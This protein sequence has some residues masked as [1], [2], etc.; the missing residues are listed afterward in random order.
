[1]RIDLTALLRDGW[2]L[3]RR[4]RALLLPL[5][6]LLLFLPDY[7]VQLL[8]PRF[9]QLPDQPMDEAATR[10]VAEAL[11]GWLV[12]YGG[13]I[14][15]AQLAGLWGIATLWTIYLDR[16]RPTLSSAFVPGL[17]LLWRYILAMLVISGGVILGMAP[18]VMLLG[19]VVPVSA[20]GAFIIAPL[21]YLLARLML[22]GPALAAER[23]LGPVAA[24]RRSWRLTRGQGWPLAWVVASITLAGYVVASLA[25]VVGDLLSPAGLANPVVVAIV[26]AIA[27]AAQCAVAVAVNL[28]GVAAYRRLSSNG[29]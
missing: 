22:I 19:L 26:A 3:W 18:I 24:I 1:M 10:A 6:G 12:D 5:V 28:V 25:L 7:A 17:A 29:N 15:L 4:D 23:P 27:V 11:V 20:L 13:W 16:R 2:K 9:T 14:L 8:V 21:F